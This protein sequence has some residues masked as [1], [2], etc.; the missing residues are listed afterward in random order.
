MVAGLVFSDGRNLSSA[1]LTA[2]VRVA[3]KSCKLNRV[4]ADMCRYFKKKIRAGKQRVF[5]S[6][7]EGIASSMPNMGEV[8]KLPC[9]FVGS[10][11]AMRDADGKRRSASLQPIS[12]ADQVHHVFGITRA[13][14]DADRRDFGDLFQ[15]TGG[16]VR[17]LSPRHFLRDICVAWC[18]GWE[19]CRRPAPAPRPARV[20][21]ACSVFWP[22]VVR[23]V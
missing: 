1:R 18:R 11:P 5:R 22:R 20:A 12:P 14:G 16:R 15:I 9:P 6:R 23:C 17:S 21:T 8:K 4:V 7:L 13:G 2:S 19:R 10:D 3:R